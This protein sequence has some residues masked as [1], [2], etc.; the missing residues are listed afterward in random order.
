MSTCRLSPCSNGSSMPRPT[1][2]PPASRAP[3]LAASMAPGPPPVMTANPASTS[4]LP[5]STPVW[6]SKDSG[7]VRAEPKTLMALPSS[8]S[9]PNPS[10]NSDWMRM[11]RQGSVC[12]QLESL[13]VSSS[14]WS[15]VPG[16]ICSRRRTTGPSRCSSGTSAAC[17]VAMYSPSLPVLR[18]RPPGVPVDVLPCQ[19]RRSAVTAGGSGH[20][21]PEAVNGRPGS[22]TAL[23][24]SARPPG[25]SRRPGSWR[26]RPARRAGG[27]GADCPGRS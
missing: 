21:R 9:A 4:A 15:V 17:G 24:R 27:R 10:T 11:T 20:G 23:R 8:A 2:T 22:G 16:W 19:P 12:T 14:R 1:E 6:Y 7:P 13:L 25:A 5:S 3:L 26:C 18:R